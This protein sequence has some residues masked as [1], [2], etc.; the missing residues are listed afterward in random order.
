MAQALP[1]PG[2]TPLPRLSRLQGVGRAPRGRGRGGQPEEGGAQG[3][4][5]RG[6]GG[7]RCLAQGAGCGDVDGRRGRTVAVAAAVAAAAEAAATLRRVRGPGWK[8]GGTWSFPPV[9]GALLPF[10][11]LL[12]HGPG[13]AGQR[14]PGEGGAVGE[15]SGPL[16]LA[17]RPCG[18]GGGP[19][20]APREAPCGAAGERPDAGVRG[21]GGR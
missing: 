18:G 2:V 5:R 11:R 14:A 17:A 12:P 9:A 1:Q 19:R 16:P 15:A 8:S 21:G 7:A 10:A 20:E 6:G 3:A 13:W 4:S